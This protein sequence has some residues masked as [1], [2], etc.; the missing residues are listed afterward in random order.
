MVT[1]IWHPPNLRIFDPMK[2]GLRRS[3]N[4]C[5]QYGILRL[6]IFDPMK[7]GLRQLL[8]GNLIQ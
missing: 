1:F 5:V 3:S 7:R 8:R 6:R 4:L 2:R